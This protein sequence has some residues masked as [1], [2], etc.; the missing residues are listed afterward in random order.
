MNKECKYCKK[1]FDTTGSN[2]KFC[3]VKCRKKNDWKTYREKRL[4][5][6]NPLRDGPGGNPSGK[7]GKDHWAYVHGEGMFESRLSPEYTKKVRYCER[8][9][10][11]LLNVSPYH[12]CVH[13]KDHNR[14]NND[15]SNFELL[16]KSCH[17]KEH[18]AARFM[19]K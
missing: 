13:H 18:D 4:A 10:K 11:D 15:E 19:H 12:R 14:S 3:S 7:L 16:C 9:N 6:G 8:C 1:N 17:Q 2:Q 5:E